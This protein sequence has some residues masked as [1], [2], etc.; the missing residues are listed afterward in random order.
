MFGRVKKGELRVFVCLVV[1]I[2]SAV[3]ASS[4]LAGIH[5]HGGYTYVGK[6]LEIGKK[7]LARHQLDCPQGTF[8]YGGGISA[9]GGFGK[10]HQRQS[11]P[12]DTKDANKDPD[13]AW[14]V[15]VKNRGKQ[16]KGRI[17]AV[18]GPEKP[19]YSIET[20]D[21]GAHQVTNEVDTNCATSVV[22]GGVRGSKGVV[23]E[24]GGPLNSSLWYAYSVNSS[25]TRGTFKQYA[26][27]AL[28]PTTYLE[29][30]GQ[31][32]PMSMIS[33]RATCPS[34]YSV[35][36]GGSSTSGSVDTTT[37]APFGTYKGWLFRGDFVG[38]FQGTSNALAACAGNLN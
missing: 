37:S 31:A 27:C 8:A 21:L 18:C 15:L 4:A 10:L 25:S 35:V 23:F 32:P 2:A 6:G 26:I 29:T 38:N 16:L 34:G 24:D 30:G 36:S 17:Y 14:G 3:T 33:H 1:A 9:K 11:Y 7:S 13:D 5:H 22:G 28:L 20:M 12:V 19:T